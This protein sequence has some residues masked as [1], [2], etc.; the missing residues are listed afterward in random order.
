[1]LTHILSLASAAAE[2]LASNP[3]LLAKL[4]LHAAAIAGV[5]RL[6]IAALRSPL[7]G[8]IWLRVPKAVR[9]LV[10]LALGVVAAVFDNLALGT[11]LLEAVFA[12]LGGIGGA[13]S[14]HEVQNR[15]LAKKAPAAS[16]AAPSPEA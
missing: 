1:M 2:P 9:P 7:L 14:S 16:P 4:A 11:P 15:V 13:I 12:A 3:D 5:L 8:L 6:V 10:I